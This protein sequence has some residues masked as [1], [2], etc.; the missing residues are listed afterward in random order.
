[1]HE[2]QI[3]KQ[4]LKLAAEETVDYEYMLRQVDKE[5]DY[6]GCIILTADR[7][8]KIMA[9]YNRLYNEAKKEM[10]ANE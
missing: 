3:L 10:E 9:E 5:G 8:D 7:D 6:S 4:A 1:M 2:L